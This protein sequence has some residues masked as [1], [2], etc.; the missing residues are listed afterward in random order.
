MIDEEDETAAMEA[1][2][3]AGL[4]RIKEKAESY[5]ED[6]ESR[7]KDLLPGNQSPAHTLFL[8]HLITTIDGYHDV[9][10]THHWES[11]SKTG[12]QTT[13]CYYPDLAEGLAVTFAFECRH[14]DAARQL[15]VIVDWDR[16]GERLPEKITNEARLLALGWRVITFTETE[17]LAA[18]DSCREK[19]EALLFDVMHEVLRDA[20]QF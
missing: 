9:V 6:L 1:A 5:R 14:D 10:V 20:G 12:W 15:A 19:V 2:E 13:F 16:P 4:R 7:W 17:I 11:R 8:A 3:K 18:V